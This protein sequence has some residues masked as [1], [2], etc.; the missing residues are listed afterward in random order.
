[1]LLRPSLRWAAVQSSALAR[2]KPGMGAWLTE[3]N[4]F[5]RRAAA[6]T[7]WA[8]GLALAAYTL[9]LL[10][11]QRVDQ[12]DVHA[13]AAS[14]PFGALFVDRSGLDFG[15]SG[16]HAFHPPRR[17]PPATRAFGRSATGIATAALLE[18]LRGARQAQPIAFRVVAPER[19]AGS[20]ATALRGE[21]F[22]AGP[23]A[24]ARA[25]V[26]NLSPVALLVRTP[27]QLASAGF[28]QRW[29]SPSTLVAGAGA[30]RYAHGRAAAGGLVLPGYSITVLAR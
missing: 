1:M 11:D 14:A 27:G 28:D 12:A 3:Y 22:G 17:D 29:A 25:I 23:G 21:L 19:V 2:L 4:L 16:S 7:T 30:L 8:Q 9:D 24:A 26:L 20:P 15:A 10:G 6:H 5:D 13:L 18:A